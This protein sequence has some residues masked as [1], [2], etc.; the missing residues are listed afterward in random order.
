MAFEASGST[1]R[2]FVGYQRAADL[3]DW[4]VIKREDE[5]G[6]PVAVLT[7]VLTN[8]DRFWI[9]STSSVRVKLRMNKCWWV[10]D[11]AQVQSLD[12]IVIW[13]YHNPRPEEL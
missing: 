7:G 8:V 1:A 9:E 2:I 3:T 13:L 5:I 12:P 4:S 11:L 10:W 6:D